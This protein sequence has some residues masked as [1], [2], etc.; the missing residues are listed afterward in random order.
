MVSFFQAD[1]RL[2]ALN[3]RIEDCCAGGMG[4]DPYPEIVDVHSSRIEDCEPIRMASLHYGR[5]HPNQFERDQ[6]WLEE[7]QAQPERGYPT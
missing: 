4:D 6:A 1:L 5:L 2:S 3:S 7:Y